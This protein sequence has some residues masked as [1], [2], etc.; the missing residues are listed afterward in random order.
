MHQAQLR[1]RG[2]SGYQPQAP[3]LQAALP[4]ALQSCGQTLRTLDL[5]LG[6]EWTGSSEPGALRDPPS[7][8]SHLLV[9]QQPRS[10]HVLVVHQCGPHGPAAFTLG[11]SSAGWAGRY[12]SQA[13]EGT[14]R[15][16]LQPNAWGR[17]R[18]HRREGGRRPQRGRVDKVSLGLGFRLPRPGTWNRPASGCR[19]PRPRA[20]RTAG[21]APGPC[22]PAAAPP[23]AP[24]AGGAPRAVV[25]LQRWER[26]GARTESQ[27]A[28]APADCRGG[29]T[30]TL[31]PR[32]SPARVLAPPPQ[33]SPRPTLTAQTAGRTRQ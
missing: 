18:G 1:L 21:P 32:G 2:L 33:A 8:R 26:K 29:P 22:P 19:K 12:R 3:L 24:A 13:G 10:R 11:P 7:A 31:C 25:L 23:P 27:Q 4:Q 17:G 15:P 20:A 30:C 14:A 16:T 6:A 5:A 28:Q 9:P